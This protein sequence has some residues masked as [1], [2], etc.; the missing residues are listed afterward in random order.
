MYVNSH[1]TQSIPHSHS[2][3]H[4]HS[5]S[6]SPLHSHSHS[7][8]LTLALTLTLTLTL[9]RLTQAQTSEVDFER[10]YETEDRY[11]IYHDLLLNIHNNCTLI[12]R[13]YIAAL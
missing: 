3:W 1:S 10:A 5:H 12:A 13:A 4:S 6:H 9:H 7:L 11:I 8:T 2:H